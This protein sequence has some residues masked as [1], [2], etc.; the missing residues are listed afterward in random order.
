MNAAAS[1]HEPSWARPSECYAAATLGPL[2]LTAEPSY[3]AGDMRTLLVS[4]FESFGGH[5]YLPIWYPSP[6][7]PYLAV[8]DG[9]G[10]RLYGSGRYSW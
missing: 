7:T 1:V 4:N 5:A 2:S 6:S 8:P 9:S 3:D 10:E